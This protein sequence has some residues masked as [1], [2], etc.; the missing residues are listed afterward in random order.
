MVDFKLDSLRALQEALWRLHTE[1]NVPNVVISSIPITQARLSWIPEQFRLRN[2]LEETPGVIYSEDALICICSSYQGTTSTV[3]ATT[4]PQI[5][6]YFAG[7]GDL[8][9]ALIL[10]HF[11]PAK[12]GEEED[13]TPLSIATS[14]ALRTIHAILIKTSRAA[15]LAFDSPKDIY[16]D[17]ELDAKDP[18]RRPRRMKARELRIVGST[19]LILSCGKDAAHPIEDLVA[20]VDFWKDFKK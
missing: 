14:H 19:N 10:G 15:S 11:Q 8:F 3:Y 4:V 12:L 18:E 1:F 17:D 16:T 20:W 9:S 6:G 13:K 7:V 5:R 2:A